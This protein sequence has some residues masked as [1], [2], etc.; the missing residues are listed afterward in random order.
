MAQG[1]CGGMD[2]HLPADP[3][4]GQRAR[5][6]LASGAPVGLLAYCWKHG[7]L[8]GTSGEPAHRS[9][10]GKRA[11]VRARLAGVHGGVA[12]D[13]RLSRIAEVRRSAAFAF[14]C[15]LVHAAL[16]PRLGIAVWSLTCFCAALPGRSGVASPGRDC[17]RAGRGGG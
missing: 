17:L 11:C 2:D 5:V 15:F 8:S 10:D 7:P 12:Y 1:R 3:E 14:T 13:R 16:A 6:D 9:R 4:S